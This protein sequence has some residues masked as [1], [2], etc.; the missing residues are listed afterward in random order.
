MINLIICCTQNYD[1]KNIINTIQKKINIID[2]FII[3]YNSIKKN[4]KILDYNINLFY[5]KNFPYSKEDFYKLNKFDIDIYG[6]EP[7]DSKLPYMC[8]CNALTYPLKNTGSHKLLLDCD[9]IAL[10]EPKFDLTCDW[11]AMFA[12][13][14]IDKK[15]YEYI[16][17]KYNYNLDLSK[18]IVGELFVKYMNKEKYE[19]FFPHFNGGAFLIKSN[20][21]ELFKKYTIESYKISYDNSVPYNIRHIGVQYGASFALYKMSKNWKPFERGFNYLGKV[22]D[23]N[24]FSKENII[25]YHYCGT[26]GEKNVSKYFS[27]YLI[28]KEIIYKKI[29]NKYF[30]NN[31]E[32]FDEIKKNNNI[33]IEI[34]DKNTLQLLK[35]NSIIKYVK[36]ILIPYNLIENKNIFLLYFLDKKIT[37][38][39]NFI[40]DKKIIQKILLNPIV[41]N[42]ININKEIDLKDFKYKINYQYEIENNI[43]YININEI[44]LFSENIFNEKF[45]VNILKK[46][47]G[48]FTSYYI[49]NLPEDILK[50]KNDD[51]KNIYVNTIK[52]F[53]NI[54]ACRPVND[55]TKEIS[56]SR[57]IKYIPDTNHFYS[58]NI[59]QPLH[60]DYAYYP[61]KNSPDYLALFCLEPSEYGGI[62]SIITTKKLKNILQKYNPKL[63]QKLN[64]DF[65]YKIYMDNETII[66]KNK[67]FDLDTNYMNWNYFQTK[68]EFNNEENI[69]IRNDF[70]K[71][72]NEFIVLGNMY[73]LN[74]KWNRGDCIIFNDYLN[75]HTRSAF[76]GTRWLADTGF[77]I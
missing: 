64:T 16:N 77:K 22:Y 1:N 49:Y 74:I 70:F 27:E 39:M 66:H 55:P 6:I 30:D 57:D 73:D 51:I 72:L 3:L 53:G 62:T 68:E 76:L 28:K 75:L 9:M 58:S 35:Y 8:R 65:N 11:Q 38:N 71:F 43:A 2:Q 17:K 46:V 19:N 54:M 31:K 52:K 26:D 44:L 47:W 33:G 67:L 69:N 15:Y 10:N 37:V 32:I 59:H 56:N 5:N 45:L 4:W 20:L 61:K 34:L 60:T 25:L 23:I 40:S 63:L 50:L 18:K 7:D 29:D 42:I 21:C 36:N 14:V 48:Y 24:K 12:N 13:S 41:N